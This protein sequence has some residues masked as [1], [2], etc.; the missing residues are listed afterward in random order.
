MENELLKVAKGIDLTEEEMLN[1]MN[2]I[3]DGKLNELE[4]ANFL[5]NLKNKGESVEEISA[6]AKVM[7]AK[8]EKIKVRKDLY[9]VDT[10]GTGGDGLNT[11]N[12]STTVAFVLASEGIAI[13]KHGNR[14]VSSKSGSADVLETLGVNINLSPKKVE[15]C[16]NKIGI[17][18]LFAPTFH[19]AMKNVAKVRRSLAFRTIFNLLGPLTN[20]ASA[21]AQIL[22]V[23]NEELTEIFASVLNNL[24]TERALIAHGLDGLDEITISDK[25]KIT[26]LNKG[27]ITTYFIEPEDFG[28]KRSSTLEIEGGDSKE[29]AEILK[30]LLNGEIQGAKR[31]ILILNSGAGLYIGNK[32][33]SLKEG[34]QLAM[35]ILDSGKAYKKLEELIAFSNE[36]DKIDIG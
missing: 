20:P 25:T 17:G 31:D 8:A 27:E 18:F 26:E 12:I 36:V 35:E 5:T 24:G 30:G 32:A 28:L 13:V 2:K 19:K 14:S 6:G 4:I 33:N 23:F 1:I 15:E 11:F 3:M 29:N 7:R 34:V 16:V 21:K 9:T 10:C 22:G